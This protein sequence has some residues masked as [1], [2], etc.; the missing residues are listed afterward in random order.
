M[1]RVIKQADVEYS[2]GQMYSLVNDIKSYPDFLPWCA[3]TDVV[4]NSGDALVA[5]VSITAGKIRQ[6]FTTANT[7]QPD[8]MITMQLVEGPFRELSGRWQFSENETGGCSVS[9]DLQF[10]FKNRLV[11][12]ALGTVFQKIID[13]LVDAF[14]DRARVIYGTK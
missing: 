7:M 8:S 1:T 12:H 2:P 5:S 3:S 6:T 11:K 13:S 9:L 10:E 4:E 14:I